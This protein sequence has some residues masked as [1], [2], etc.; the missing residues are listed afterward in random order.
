MTTATTAAVSDTAHADQALRF[1]HALSRRDFDE[2]ERLLASNVWFRALL[3]R[4][5]YELNRAEET[6]DILRRW[7]GEAKKFRVLRT[8]HHTLAGREFILYRF[9]LLPDW[10]PEQWHIIEQAGFMRVK[11]G[12]ISRLDLVCTGFFPADDHT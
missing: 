8:E 2:I 9:L 11:E 6:L 12:R 5:A 3:P 10:A 1:L 7:F 4:K